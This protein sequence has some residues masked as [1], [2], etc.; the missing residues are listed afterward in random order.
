MT[1]TSILIGMFSFALI[2]HGTTAGAQME[3]NSATVIANHIIADGTVAKI[4][5]N[6]RT[7]TLKL[8]GGDQVNLKVSPDVLQFEQIKK[9]DPVSVDYLE[10][11]S[12]SLQDAGDATPAA[13]AESYH[14]VVPGEKPTSAVVNTQE[15]AATV[16]S[17]DNAKRIVTLRGPDGETVKLH[18]SPDAGP[19]D[20]VKKG[21]QVI[22]RYTQALALD[23]R[24]TG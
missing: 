3:A 2:C 10:A 8:P 20:Q 9:G 22:A 24:K 6:R 19:L 18:M 14:I 11:V 12:L 16:E 5:H 21:D 1:R 7:M 23:V 15:V 17:V 13:T 4:D